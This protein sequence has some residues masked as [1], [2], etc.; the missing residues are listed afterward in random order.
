MEPASSSIDG[1]TPLRWRRD[2]RTLW[3]AGPGRIV[4]FL[5]H[6]ATPRSLR[7]TGAALWALLDRPR[8][9]QEIETLLAAEFVADPDVVRRDI[10]HVITQLGEAGAIRVES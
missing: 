4:V 6:D 5:D 1:A 9:M 10:E 2:E 7:D 3:R 8:T